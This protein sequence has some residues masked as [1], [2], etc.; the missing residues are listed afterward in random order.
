[1][2]HV[3]VSILASSSVSVSATYFT[4]V[5]L[6]KGA[7]IDIDDDPSI[8]IKMYVRQVNDIS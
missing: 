7:E 3:F 2:R 4:C 1:V 6:C 8:S 5:W